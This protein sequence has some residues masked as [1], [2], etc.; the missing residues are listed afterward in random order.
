MSRFAFD[1]SDKTAIVTGAGSGLG[2][3]IAFA[4]AR[5][6]ANVT[7]NDI[8]PDRVAVTADEI[9]STGGRAFAW[10]AD[11][12]NRFQASA[13]I[14]HTRDEFGPVHFL[15]NAAGAYRAT[16]FDQVDEWDW[17]RQIDVNLTGAFF[18][19][20][21]ISR[22]L[23]GDTEDERGGAIVNLAYTFANSTTPDGAGY[24]ASKAGLLGLTR[25]AAVELAPRNIRVNA[26]CPGSIDGDDMPATPGENALKRSGSPEEVATAV[27]FLCSD[28]ASFIT[29]QTLNVD[30]GSA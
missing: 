13:L 14:E 26:V 8:N 2:R 10:Q 9:N 22:V 4:F 6:G 7:V 24:T 11:I 27:L 19:T 5:S 16:P 23:G 17:R 29:G 15:I 1:F 25:Q 18:M 20:Q 21:L 30:G 12:A 3:A 28:A